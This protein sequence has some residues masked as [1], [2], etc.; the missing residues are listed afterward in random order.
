M[1]SALLK[2]DRSDIREA[3]L[4]SGR[5]LVQIQGHSVIRHLESTGHFQND[6]Q[7]HTDADDF[8]EHS[9]SRVLRKASPFTILSET[10]PDV[11]QETDYV[12][13]LDPIDGT[14]Q[15]HLG[16]PFY[17]ISVA[18]CRA[19][20][21]EAVWGLVYA[22]TLDLFYEATQDC[23]AACNGRRIQNS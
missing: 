14:A 16:L 15:Y 23:G 10:H 13:I 12:W 5:R 8:S 2:I 6:P 9:I 11:S 18:L 22:P 7:I 21:L 19:Q 3:I 20:T 4:A 17:T 1:R